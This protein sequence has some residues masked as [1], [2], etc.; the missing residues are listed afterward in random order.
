MPVAGVLS[1]P[2]RTVRFTPLGSPWAGPKVLFERCHPCPAGGRRVRVQGGYRGWVHTGWVQGR[3]IPGTTHPPT[4]LC[5]LNRLS[6]RCSLPPQPALTR[7]AVGLRGWL[8]EEWVCG[9]PSR[10][11]SAHGRPVPASGP[12]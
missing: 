10:A 11:W 12:I 5:S 1:V 9:G 3:G 6:H 8:L 4:P 7:W 2:Q